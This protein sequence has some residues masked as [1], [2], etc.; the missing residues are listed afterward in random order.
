MNIYED[1]TVEATFDELTDLV[2]QLV[3]NLMVASLRNIVGTHQ[4][5]QDIVESRPQPK[6][7]ELF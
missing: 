1:Q 7:A 4:A 3:M 2:E 5:H 6:Q